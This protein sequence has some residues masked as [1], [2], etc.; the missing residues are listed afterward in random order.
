MLFRSD[1]V[2]AGSIDIEEMRKNVDALLIVNNERLCDV[3]A[4]SEITVK[5]AFKLADKELTDAMIKSGAVCLA[6]ETVETDNHLLPLLIS[7]VIRCGA[8]S[9]GTSTLPTTISTSGNSLRILCS[10]E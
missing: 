4:D 8:L 3:Y 5:D 10:L 1:W 7:F 9:P 2:L 6:Y